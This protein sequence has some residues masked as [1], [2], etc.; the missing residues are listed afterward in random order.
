MAHGRSGTVL[1][2]DAE[3]GS[4]DVGT[5]PGGQRAARHRPRGRRRLGGRRALRER[6]PDRRRHPAPAPGRRRR[7]PHRPRRPRRRRLG[8]G[9]VRRETSCGSTASPP[10][11]SGSTSVPPSPGSRSPMAASGWSRERSPPRATSAVSCASCSPANV[12]STR[13]SGR[14]STRPASTTSGAP[15]RAASSTT[16]WSP[17]STR[18]PTPRCW[19]RTSPTRSPPRPT[20]AGPTSSTSGPGS[21][22]PPVPRSGP[23]TS[24]SVCSARCTPSDQRDPTSTPGSSGARRASTTATPCDLRAGA[25]VA[26]DAA[27]RVTFH[28]EAPDPLFLYKLTLFVVPTPPGT[29]VGELDSPLPGTGPYQVAPRDEGT[30]LTLARNPWFQ[31]VVAPRAAGR[32]PRHDHLADRAQRG[33]GGAGG[34]AGSRGPH[35]RDRDRGADG[36]RSDEAARRAPEGHG[37]GPAPRQPGAGHRLPG[38][39]LLATPVRQPPGASRPELRLR[40]HEGDRA[41]RRAVA[42]CTPRAS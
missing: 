6:H 3:T 9:E 27:G 28:L 10:T 31:P 18:A 29:P 25:V 5:D 19:S 16:G 30:V 2:I 37:A 15:S 26:D 33:R 32:L 1:Q 34:G 42:R 39:Q 4:P 41:G 24:C 11:S 21:G 7:R 40:P 35:R 17:C 12:V 8:G 36:A 23:P 22:T 38:P 13:S 20:G 14:R